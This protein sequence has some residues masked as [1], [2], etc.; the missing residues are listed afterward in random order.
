[1]G[2]WKE[3]IPLFLGSIPTR[4]RGQKDGNSWP[5]EAELGVVGLVVRSSS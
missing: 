3:G 1:M 5:A 4:I 2:V